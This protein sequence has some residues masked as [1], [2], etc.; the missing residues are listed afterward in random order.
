MSID[1]TTLSNQQL[2]IYKRNCE[3]L[4]HPEKAREAARE[5]IRRGIAKTRDLNVFKWNQHSVRE[6]MR[7]FMEIASQVKDNQLTAYTEAGGFKIGRPKGHPEK[8]WIDTYCAIKTPEMKALFGCHVKSPGD[9]PTFELYRDGT[10]SS[11]DADRLDRAFEDWAALGS[12][13]Q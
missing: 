13:I 11:Y 5:M 1:L 6:A 9:E 10:I 3:R 12:L 8:Q 7:R 2:R 4:G